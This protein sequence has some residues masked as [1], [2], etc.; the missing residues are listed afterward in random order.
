VLGFSGVLPAGAV[1]ALAVLSRVLL[2]VADIALAA[3]FLLAGRAV[4]RRAPAA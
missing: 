1:L 2:I 4:A 3:V